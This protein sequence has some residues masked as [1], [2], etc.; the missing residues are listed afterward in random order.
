MSDFDPIN[1]I[2][3]KELE[4]IIAREECPILV[5][6][7]ASWLATGS[8]L[9]DIVAR[10]STEFDPGD[11]LFYQVDVERSGDIVKKYGITTLPTTLV[12][13]D[14]EV[15]DHFT[16]VMNINKLRRRLRSLVDSHA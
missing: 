10:I 8:M 2:D 6:F 9:G 11:I 16:G 7:H 5:I 3:R 1:E 4:E 14:G 13:C 15:I 12:F